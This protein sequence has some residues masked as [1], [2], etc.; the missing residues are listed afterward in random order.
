M[1]AGATRVVASLW[2]VDDIATSELMAR[3]YKTMQRDKLSPSAALRAAQI[4]MLQQKH[5]NSPFYWA[6][7]QI[8]GEWR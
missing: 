3:F 2:G 4:Q 6:A 8:H 1:Y 5:W 7:F